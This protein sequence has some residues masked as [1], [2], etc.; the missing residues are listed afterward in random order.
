MLQADNTGN[1]LP[2]GVFPV[3]F[4]LSMLVLSSLSDNFHSTN[5]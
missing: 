3:F 4:F 5:E 1:P 2:I